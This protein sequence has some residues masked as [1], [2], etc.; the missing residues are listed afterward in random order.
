MSILEMKTVVKDHPHPAGDIHVL[1]GATASIEKGESVA[2]LGQSGSGKSTLLSLLAGLDKPTSGSLNCAGH[3]LETLSEEQ[4]TDYRAKHLGIVFQ[5]FH[6]MAHLTALENVLLPLK[7]AGRT[8]IFESA[9]SALD[10]VG[11]S[12]RQDHLPSELSGGESQRVAIA[13]AMVASPDVILADEPSGNLD[14]KTGSTVMGILFD[15][16]KKNN[17]TLVLVTHNEDLAQLCDR[18]LRLEEGLLK[19]I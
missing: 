17:S 16:V 4:L 12:Q 2:I 11:L 7:I 6:L 5:Q 13:R 1:R 9:R 19:P 14:T 10:S 18:R 15:L 3:A 8:N